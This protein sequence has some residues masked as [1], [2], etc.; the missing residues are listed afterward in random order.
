MLV[1][2]LLLRQQPHPRTERSVAGAAVSFHVVLLL[3]LL[4][5]ELFDF[6]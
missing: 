5:L 4:L 2:V 6:V 1:D 3:L